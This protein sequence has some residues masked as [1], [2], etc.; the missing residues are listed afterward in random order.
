MSGPP[1][2]AGPGRAMSVGNGPPSAGLGPHPQMGQPP[3]A[4]PPPAGGPPG[5][6]SQQNLNQI[7]SR[8]TFTHLVSLQTLLL[9][10]FP[11]RPGLLF[12][13]VCPLW[14]PTSS[15]LGARTSG[16]D[17]PQAA[18]SWHNTRVPSTFRPCRRT[19][20]CHQHQHT[21]YPRI[22]PRAILHTLRRHT[23]FV[24]PPTIPR[25]ST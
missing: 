23:P 6:Q 1:P 25:H 11:A 16:N 17:H 7:V 21:T 3:P 5:P 22:L 19:H 8:E 24:R 9:P 2:G 20:R 10:A 14:C 15:A 4:V 13:F 18:L 12:A